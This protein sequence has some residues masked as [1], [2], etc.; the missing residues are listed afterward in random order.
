M[1]ATDQQVCRL[2]RLVEAC[3]LDIGSI[4]D[5]M[6]ADLSTALDTAELLTAPA[7]PTGWPALISAKVPAS[8]DR[9][10]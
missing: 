6:L 8:A 4:P 1:I 10:P 5:E 2:A 7:W 9:A 3:G